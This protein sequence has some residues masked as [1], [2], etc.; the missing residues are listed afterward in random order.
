MTE[1]PTYGPITPANMPRLADLN[2]DTTPY[3]CQITVFCDECGD[4]VTAD[5]L[6]PADSAS[7]GRL[8]IAREHLRS[9]GW[10]C[11]EAGDYCPNC[12]KTRATAPYETE[13]DQP[14]CPDCGNGCG[15][16]APE[17]YHVDCGENVADCTCPNRP[18]PTVSFRELLAAN[19][20]TVTD[21]TEILITAG[22]LRARLDE[23]GRLRTQADEDAALVGW[24]LYADTPHSMRTAVLSNHFGARAQAVLDAR[25]AAL[26][27]GGPRDRAAQLAM[28]RDGGGGAQPANAVNEQFET[29]WTVARHG[30][31]SIQY[32][33]AMTEQY[34]RDEVREELECGETASVA[35]RTVGPW[36]HEEPE[37][38]QHA[39]ALN[40]AMK[41]GA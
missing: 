9:I 28:L 8:E 2:D 33:D 24:Y 18:A 39:D 6:V 37:A 41:A 10:S 16:H 4:E 12:V 11:N 40:A 1:Q 17:T 5:Y 29:E 13:T 35:Y 7:A 19:P 38:Q 15:G 31:R 22:E 3:P 36:Q 23:L 21:D 25:M 14:E 34:A 26:P 32:G 27:D 30:L 20:D